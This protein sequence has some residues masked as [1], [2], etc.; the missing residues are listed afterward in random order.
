MTQLGVACAGAVLLL[1]PAPAVQQPPVFSARATGVR[2]DALVTER[3]VP[4][5]GLTATDFELRDNGILQDI[6]IVESSDI[7]LNVV[8][9]FDGSASTG[10][11]RISDLVDA[12][13]AL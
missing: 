12:G 13:N 1:V 3:N 4:V 9:A 10:G 5:R 11:R 2:V 8:L 7:P 6:D